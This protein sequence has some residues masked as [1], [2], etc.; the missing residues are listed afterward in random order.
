MNYMHDMDIPYYT[1]HLEI[2]LKNYSRNKLWYDKKTTELFF[3]AISKFFF[4]T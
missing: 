4:I 2:F 3:T 1:P